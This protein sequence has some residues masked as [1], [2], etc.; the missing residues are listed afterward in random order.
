MFKIGNKEIKG[1]VVLAPMAGITSSGYRSFMGKF[2]PSIMYTEMISDMGLIYENEETLSYLKFEKCD[3]PIGVQLFGSEPKNLAKAASIVKKHVPFVDFIDVN[4]ACPVPKVTKTGAGS[5]LL[6]NPKKC[7]EIIREI[8]KA[9]GLP[10][11]AKIRLGYY[12]SNLNYLEVIKELEDAG[13]LFIA[14]HAKG[15]KQLYAGIPQY[16]LIKNL[17]EQMHVPLIISG[18]IFTAEEA[19]KA[20]EITKADAVM[21]ARGGIGNPLLITQINEL[22]EEGE[23]KS[24]SNLDLQIEYCQQLALELIK[25]KQEDKAMRIYRG[26][27]PKFFS[28]YKNMK[29]YKG[30]IST[31][32]SDYSSLVDILEQIKKDN[33]DD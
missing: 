9:T 3:I 26:I 7:G 10:V 30:M 33:L 29:K 8:K 28:G 27:G 15:A 17:R 20:L 14:L 23:I 32:L 31:S 16:E 22:L 5:A 12:D 4:M 11:S 19:K 25:E 2:K 24:F 6:L 18:N 1:R 13:V 21:V